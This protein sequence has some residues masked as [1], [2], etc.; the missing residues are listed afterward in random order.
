MLPAGSLRKGCERM[1][2]YIIRRIGARS[3][4]R[5]GSP[6]SR[7]RSA[8]PGA[9]ACLRSARFKGVS[10]DGCGLGQAPRL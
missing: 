2:G 6:R 8:R 5:S 7:T 9:D 3:W 10:G 1:L 4:L